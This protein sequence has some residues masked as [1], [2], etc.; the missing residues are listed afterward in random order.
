MSLDLFGWLPFKFCGFHFGWKFVD[1]V[2]FPRQ[3]SIGLL[4]KQCVWKPSL[5]HYRQLICSQSSF[6][7]RFDLIFVIQSLSCFWILII[8]ILVSKMISKQANKKN[9]WN[10]GLKYIGMGLF[11]HV[12]DLTIIVTKLESWIKIVWNMSVRH[13]KYPK[14]RTVDMI[15]MDLF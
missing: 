15:C 8:R 13:G 1:R 4:S 3:R 6:V 2:Y 12:P 10:L 5:L 9:K 14:F 11:K 7:M